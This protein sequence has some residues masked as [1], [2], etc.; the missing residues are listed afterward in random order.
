MQEQKKIAVAI[1]LAL[2][3]NPPAQD[4]DSRVM[5]FPASSEAEIITFP[6]LK[7]CLPELGVPEK[8]P[9]SE[10][11]WDGEGK[12]LCQWFRQ[13]STDSKQLMEWTTKE[14]GHKMSAEE[15][16]QLVDHFPWH[17][18]PPKTLRLFMMM[19]DPT[20]IY[21]YIHAYIA[22]TVFAVCD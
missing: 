12:C 19:C 14:I 16:Q 5:R 13:T 8:C 1:G 2:K 21:Y 3:A 7:D 11:D 20:H 15:V 4:T 6:Y 17:L 22:W 9:I 10:Y 18:G